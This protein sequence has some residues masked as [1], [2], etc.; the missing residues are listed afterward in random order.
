MAADQVAV[1]PT[2]QKQGPQL[3]TMVPFLMVQVELVT[4]AETG[5]V[6]PGVGVAVGV[7]VEALDISHGDILVSH[8]TLMTAEQEPSLQDPTGEQ[9]GQV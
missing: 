2:V 5:A 8:T 4:V 9:L 3:V 7:L 6:T 1:P